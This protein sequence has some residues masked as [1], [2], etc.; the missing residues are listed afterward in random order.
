MPVPVWLWR[1]AET[2]RSRLLNGDFLRYKAK[3][4]NF[5]MGDNMIGKKEKFSSP[6]KV[7]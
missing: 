2:L 6:S 1:A 4:T 3:T 7:N 5:T